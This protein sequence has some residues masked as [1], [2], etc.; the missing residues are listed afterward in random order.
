M[1]RKPLSMRAPGQSAVLV[2]LVLVLLVAVAGLGLD[3]ANAFNQ[4][5][6]AQNAADAA[7]MAAASSL[8]AQRKVSGPD[9]AVY[10]T[11]ESYLQDH[12]VDLSQNPWTAHYIDKDE[13]TIRNVLDNSTQVPDNARGVVVDLNY[14]FNTLFMPVLGR[15]SLA[16]TGEAT[17]MFGP[18]ATYGGSDVVPFTISTDGLAALLAQNGGQGAEINTT[19]LGPGNFGSLIFNPSLSSS[20]VGSDCYS[21]SYVD[22]LS[23]YWC[24]GT[25]QYPVYMGEN[26]YV[27][28]GAVATS[29][30]SE[31]NTRLNETMIVPIFSGNAGT[32]GNTQMTIVGFI[33]VKLTAINLTG[34]VEDRGFTVDFIENV[35]TTGAFNPNGVDGGV[36]A[37]NLV[38]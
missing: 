1:N 30:E 24:N 21:P 22:S 11:I 25:P 13:A 10:N 2:G 14:T 16:V 9:S 3:G 12:S 29:L 33:A 6:N 31:I 19:K 7:A 34:A 35:T 26:L 20:T 38:K 36:Y 5:R 32:G 18:A 15:N 4:R 23:Y 37:I 8:I 17:A 28:P 27:K